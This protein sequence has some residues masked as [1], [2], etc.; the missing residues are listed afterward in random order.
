MGKKGKIYYVKMLLSV[1]GETLLFLVFFIVS[2][3]YLAL[4]TSCSPAIPAAFLSSA[5]SPFPACSCFGCWI[6]RKASPLEA[7][8]LSKYL[9]CYITDEQEG[10]KGGHTES[11]GK[12]SHVHLQHPG[13]LLNFSSLQHK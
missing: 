9:L 8:P 10:S 2:W 13:V 6:Q 4:P 5:C 11:C 3:L 7:A 1:A 12:C